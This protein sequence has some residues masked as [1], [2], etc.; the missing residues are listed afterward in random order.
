METR[1]GI[2]FHKLY[3]QSINESKCQKKEWSNFENIQPEIPLD[4]FSQQ[5]FM[6]MTALNLSYNSIKTNQM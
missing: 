4:S 5:N 2:H 1:K 6:F 3:Q